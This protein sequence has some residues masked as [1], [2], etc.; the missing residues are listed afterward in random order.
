MLSSSPLSIFLETALP[1]DRRGR[2]R[3]KKRSTWRFTDAMAEEV[4][5]KGRPD[6]VFI[7][8]KVGKRRDR[9]VHEYTES[10]H[11]YTETLYMYS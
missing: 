5:L 3:K 1:R 7:L 2:R 9:V 8:G 6:N 11:T 4:A 10:T